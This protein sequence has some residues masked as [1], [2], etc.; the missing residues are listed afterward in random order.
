[1]IKCLWLHACS[2]ISVKLDTFKT[3]GIV[4]LSQGAYISGL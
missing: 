3:K 2:V 4:V 1:M